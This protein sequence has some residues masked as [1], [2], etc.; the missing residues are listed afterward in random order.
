MNP[1]PRMRYHVELV[2]IQPDGR[3]LDSDRNPVMRRA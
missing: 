1:S 3:V 2:W